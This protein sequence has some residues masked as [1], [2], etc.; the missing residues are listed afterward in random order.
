MNKII[1][2]IILY[3]F[4]SLMSSYAIEFELSDIIKQARDA[5]I[6]KQKQIINS[7]NNI[8]EAKKQEQNKEKNN[9]TEQITNNNI[10]REQ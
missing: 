7:E 10:K 2:C 4:T 5:E 1:F 6:M 3:S 8:K 9:N